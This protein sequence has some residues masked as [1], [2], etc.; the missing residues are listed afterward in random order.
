MRKFGVV[1]AEN[2]RPLSDS[3]LKAPVVQEEQDVEQEVTQLDEE[4]IKLQ[5]MIEEMDAPRRS[6]RDLW[7]EELEWAALL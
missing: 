6:P 5:E 1:D 7:L 2:R 4:A 3:T